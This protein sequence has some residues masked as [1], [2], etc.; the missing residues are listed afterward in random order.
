MKKLSSLFLAFVLLFLLVL[1][2]G[3][4]GDDLPLMNTTDVTD[5]VASPVYNDIENHWAGTAIQTW[6]NY[7]VIQGYAGQF[8][9]ADNITRAELATVL[10]RLL[11]LREMG[12]N[13]FADLDENWY[14]DA[15]LRCVAV[16]ILKGDGSRIRPNDP[17]T[18]QEAMVMLGR[19]L[20]IAEQGSSTS[21]FVDK[22]EVADWALGFVNALTERQIV[23]GVGQNRLAPKDTIDRASVVT[24]LDKAISI[25]VK[26]AGTTVA[27]STGNGSGIVLI[28]GDNTTLTGAFS[29]DILVAQGAGA[30]N[31][32]E[33]TASGSISILGAGV[34]VAVSGESHIA[35]VRVLNQANQVSLQVGA[36][37]VVQQ[38]VTAADNTAVSGAGQVQGVIAAHGAT[39]ANVTT[40]ETNVTAQNGSQNTLACGNVV[41]VGQTV[42]TKKPQEEPGGGPTYYTVS[43]DANG[44]STVAT[45]SM[46]SGQ[47]AEEPEAPT[48]NGYQFVGWYLNDSAT[49]YDFDTPVKKSITLTA[50]WMPAKYTITFETNGGSAVAPV[51]KVVGTTIQAPSSPTKGG[52]Q[53][54]GWYVDSELTQPYVFSR[55]PAKNVTLYAAWEASTITLSFQTAVGASRVDPIVQA[56]GA[57][58]TE[59]AAPTRNGYTFVGWYTDS[60]LTTPFVFDVMPTV[61]MTLYSKWDANT[62]TLTFETNGGNTIAPI[63]QQYLTSVSAPAV[64][65]KEGCSF[66]GWYSDET[67]TTKFN[68]ATMPAESKTLY[69]K[70]DE[71]NSTVTLVFDC[72]YTSS[73]G[74]ASETGTAGTPVTLKVPTR[75]GYVFQ[76]WYSDSGMTTL[77]AAAPASGTTFAGVFPAESKTLYAKWEPKSITLSFNL[78]GG[79]VETPITPITQ[80]VGTPVAVPEQIPVKEGATFQYWYYGTPNNGSFFPGVMPESNYNVNLYA[81][82]QVNSHTLTYETNG[83]DAI[84]AV[85]VNY[86]DQMSAVLPTPTKEGSFFVG[87]YEDEGLTTPVNLATARMPDADKTVYAKWETALAQFTGDCT[88]NQWQVNEDGIS[89]TIMLDAGYQFDD[90]YVSAHH[91]EIIDSIDFYGTL[92]NKPTLEYYP[93]PMEQ[94]ITQGLNAYGTSG[95]FAYLDVSNG[96]TVYDRFVGLDPAGT[97]STATITEET[98]AAYPGVQ[99]GI[100]DALKAGA[101]F[102]LSPDGSELTIAC[103]AEAADGYF[104]AFNNSVPVCNGGIQIVNCDV[105][106]AMTLPAGMIEG[107]DV[108][109]KMKGDSYYTIQE[110]K[111]HA[112]IWE[113]VS[114]TEALDGEGQVKDGYFKIT[115]N[116]QGTDN[117]A[118]PSD[119]ENGPYYVKQSAT[120]TL[121]EA[122]VRAGGTYGPNG[123]GHK[124]VKICIDSRVG[125][126]QWASSKNMSTFFSNLFRTSKD[127]FGYSGG[128]LDT[129]LPKDDSEWLKVENNIVNGGTDSFAPYNVVSNKYVINYSGNSRN[130]TANP[131]L[132]W[133]FYEIP[134]T[135]GF[136]ISED[137]VIYCN[138]IA[139]FYGGSGQSTPV[140]GQPIIGM[141]G[142]F[143]FLIEATNDSDLTP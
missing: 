87:W 107:V 78:A 130:D 29:G 103:T 143:T 98:K 56:A 20:A 93:V 120:D 50:K 86:N 127:A 89:M 106:M 36:N 4:V 67:L 128:S 64:P 73:Q 112:E 118:S 85:T 68:F 2:A 47:K 15:M 84:E 7:G 110:M 42:L 121:T 74:I 88:I 80:A 26:R 76:G 77:F 19:A 60:G 31:L 101:T 6:S 30:F 13:Q 21:S 114:A 90:E 69:A 100:R 41:P 66:A 115:S 3:A 24:I 94:F 137:M 1:P 11:G 28:A 54:G 9:P 83:G 97:Q 131:A 25:Y 79:T 113:Y 126:S 111:M 16:G 116:I 139:G 32:S 58:I 48:R 27:G 59:P 10:D 119:Y 39:N 43:F 40:Y 91:N 124:L 72:N 46:I 81:Y 140:N 8:R 71:T 123:T 102:T 49:T 105:L 141:D 34:S 138:M 17:I 133:M 108:D 122:E 45:Q 63:T 38:V 129:Y 75:I 142:R 62:Y 23:N 51:T 82:Y 135:P 55:M 12:Q 61:N 70:W 65:V 22:E 53:F 33:A 44:G 37:A 57:P 132:M 14:T 104:E 52:F 18:R 95:Y 136:N 35:Q 134:K 117:N 125:P 5:S 92:F 109:T 96:I 99:K